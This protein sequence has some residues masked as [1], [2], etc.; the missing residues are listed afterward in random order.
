MFAVTFG[1]RQGSVLSP[2]L[3]NVYVNDLANI[4]TDLRW[5][6]LVL[7]A[8]DILLM[9]YQTHAAYQNRR[10]MKFLRTGLSH[11]INAAQQLLRQELHVSKNC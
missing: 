7:Y 9:K 4:D 8:D 1:V 5:L 10:I 3:F 2:I 6:Y 11:R